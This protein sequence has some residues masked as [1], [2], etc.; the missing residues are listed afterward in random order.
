M[1]GYWFIVA[2]S[3]EEA[4]KIAAANPCLAYGLSLEVRPIDPEKGSAFVE[5]CETPLR[6][7]TASS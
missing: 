4:A 7:L 6:G 5:T 3:I 2:A 1:G